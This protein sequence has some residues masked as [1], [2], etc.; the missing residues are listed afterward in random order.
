MES[1]YLK[2]SQSVR[3]CNTQ[4]FDCTNFVWKS[5]LCMAMICTCFGKA[6]PLSLLSMLR[7]WHGSSK[8]HFNV[9]SYDAELGRDSNLSP[10]IKINYLKS[11]F[12][13]KVINLKYLFASCRSHNVCMFVFFFVSLLFSL[14]SV[15]NI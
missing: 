4:V 13:N 10:P 14:Q 3:L 6:F 9:F 12:N 7:T 11:R 1:N 15:Y 2:I 8:N 5:Q